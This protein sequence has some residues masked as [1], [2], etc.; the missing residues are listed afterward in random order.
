MLTGWMAGRKA[1]ELKMAGLPE[2]GLA[3][4]AG[5]FGSDVTCT[6][7]CCAGTSTTGRPMP[8]VW[9]PTP[10]FREERSMR[11]M[12]SRCRWKQTLFFAGEHTDT[13]GHWGTVHG[14]LRSGYR[15]A[16]QVL[17]T[18]SDTNAVSDG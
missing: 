15:A 9:A 4:L 3:T 8:T 14:A 18:P 17:A 16:E 2:T 7:T 13:S 12:S 10:M 11:P 5:F 6:S 1:T